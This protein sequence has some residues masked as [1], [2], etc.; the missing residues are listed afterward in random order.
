MVERGSNFGDVPEEFPVVT[1]RASQEFLQIKESAL[2]EALW[3]IDS[4]D[5][6]LSEPVKTAVQR[7]VAIFGGERE[8]VSRGA[9]MA[10]F[11]FYAMADVDGI[12][13]PEVELADVE[14]LFEK[15]QKRRN[16]R[17]NPLDIRGIL[18]ETY[19]ESQVEQQNKGRFFITIGVDL[20]QDIDAY[21]GASVN[22]ELRRR[23]WQ[24]VR[25]GLD[26]R[27]L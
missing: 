7:T 3:F 12:Q 4:F 24:Q 2:S 26:E 27:E 22:Y 9:A 19:P 17:K 21:I 23:K 20:V 16:K 15:F 1:K 13:L 8:D 10:E 18:W 25:A 6:Y 11:G 5:S 14:V